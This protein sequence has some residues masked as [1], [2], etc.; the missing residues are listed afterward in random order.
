MDESTIPGMK[1]QHAIIT[2][3]CVAMRGREGA[4]DEALA[5]A[6]KELEACMAGWEGH[7]CNFHVAVTVER[8]GSDRRKE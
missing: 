3:A 5:R 4:I 1:A 7:D 2:P 6:R 8:L